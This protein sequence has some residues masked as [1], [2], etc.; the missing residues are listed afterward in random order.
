MDDEDKIPDADL[1]DDEDD[2]TATNPET[3]G[4]KGS[5]PDDAVQTEEEEAEEVTPHTQHLSPMH[6]ITL[7]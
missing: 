3:E 2:A 7:H 1:D 6:S 5:G 4:I